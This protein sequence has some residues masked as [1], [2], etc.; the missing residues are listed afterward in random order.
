MEKMD[1]FKGDKAQFLPKRTYKDKMTVGSGK[2]RI[3]LYYFGPGH[4]NGDTWIVYPALRVMQTGDMFAV[5]GRA[6]HRSRTTAA[7]A[8]S[9]PK[10]LGKALATIKDVDTVIAGHSPLRNAR[11]A[12]GVSAVHDRLRRAV[13]QREEGGQERRRCGGVDRSRG[14]YKDYKKDRYKAAIQAM[15][16]ELK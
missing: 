4:T 3:D 9:T 7:A 15:Y 12:P 11:R 5:E 6:A 14:K 1:A 16:D 8:S 13:R 2:D 10:T